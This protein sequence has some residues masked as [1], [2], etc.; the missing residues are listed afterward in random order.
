MAN[1]KSVKAFLTQQE[2]DD[3]TYESKTK[4]YIYDVDTEEVEEY[5]PLDCEGDCYVYSISGDSKGNYYILLCNYENNEDDRFEIKIADDKSVKDTLSVK[6]LLGDEDIM[7]VSSLSAEGDNLILDCYCGDSYSSLTRFTVNPDTKEMQKEALDS[8][9]RS[10]VADDGNEY[11]VSDMGVF[12][13]EGKSDK[14]EKPTPVLSFDDC[15]IRR[16]YVE[17]MKVTHMSDTE[18]TMV[19]SVYTNNVEDNGI[20]IYKFTKAESNPNA[21]KTVVTVGAVDYSAYNIYDS[22]YDFNTTNENYFVKITD[23]Y[24]DSSDMDGLDLNSAEAYREYLNNHNSELVNSLTIDILGGD[25][26]DVILGAHDFIQLKDGKFLDDISSNFE[27]NKNGEYFENVLN[28]CKTDDKLY[29]MPLSFSV[30]GIFAKEEDVG[31]GKT[32]FTFDE[33][34]KFVEGPCNGTDPVY[35]SSRM[36]YFQSIF[37]NMSDVFYD[38]DGNIDLQNETFYELAQYC[39]DNVP[40]SYEDSD[41]EDYIIYDDCYGEGGPV[42]TWLYS[43]ENFLWQAY[44]HGKKINTLYGFPS[45][46]GRGPSIEI[47]TSAA[48]SATS[49]NKDGAWEFIQV[50]L[51]DD[52]QKN[53][54]ESWNNPISKTALRSFSEDKL[55]EMN[56]D[57]EKAMKRDP[58]A[59]FYNTIYEESTIDDYIETLES[60]TSFGVQDPAIMKIIDEEIQAYFAGQKSIE[61]VTETI[62]NRAKTVIDERK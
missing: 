32:G 10:S 3:R 45:S 43:Y 40:E 61:D 31:K 23:K 46:D 29:F 41:D 60:A 2:Y 24:T 35:S 1:D 49:S 48:I 26:P 34:K 9:Y 37:A 20:Y 38:A 16:N 17:G 42:A 14:K 25:A 28:V 50:L 22:L 6:D 21:G 30:N 56:D 62:Q 57:A 36:E 8:Y 19:G 4:G 12:K 54:C 15:N 44:D 55:K 58:Q 5:A 11:Y 39:K 59:K 33:Y 53:I 18:C 51:S 47:N 13:A 7:Y 27:K 52:F